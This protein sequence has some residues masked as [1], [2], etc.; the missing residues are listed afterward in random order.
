M[1]GKVLGISGIKNFNSLISENANILDVR[2]PE[3]NMQNIPCKNNSFDFVISDQV[4]EHLEDSKKA[5]KES[6]RV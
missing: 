2:Y 1:N 5:V 4:F 6:Y 3:I